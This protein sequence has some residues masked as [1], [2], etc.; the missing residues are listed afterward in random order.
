MPRLSRVLML[1]LP[2]LAGIYP[3]NG[4]VPAQSKLYPPAG[5]WRALH[6]LN[7]QS[8]AALEELAGQIPTLSEMGINVLILE[9]DYG[10][11][12]QSHPELRMGDKPITRAGAR[13]FTQTCRTHGIRLIPQFACVGHQSWAKKTYTLLTVYP[14]LDLTPGAFPE[15]EGIYCFDL[16]GDNIYRSKILKFIVKKLGL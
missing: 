14:E 15:N 12:Y 2:V 11:A 5:Q 6:V 3:V 7:Y 8:D 16:T 1:V 10:F 13:Q 9:V 4:A